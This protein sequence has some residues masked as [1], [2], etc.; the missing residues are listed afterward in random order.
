MYSRPPRR[1]DESWGKDDPPLSFEMKIHAWLDV[2]WSVFFLQFF[3][4]FLS[5]YEAS[6]LRL[7]NFIFCLTSRKKVRW[8]MRQRR[9][10]GPIKSGWAAKKCS[11]S[12]ETIESRTCNDEIVFFH[13]FVVNAFTPI[14]IWQ[15]NQ[16]P[17]V[18]EF[19]TWT[20]NLGNVCC[21]FFSNVTHAMPFIWQVVVWITMFN[22]QL[23]RESPSENH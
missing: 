12:S 22:D 10:R 16:K 19:W 7:K 1:C 11:K 3:Q 9:K 17:D 4:I 8:K 18:S 23:G 2:T 21:Y 14:I 13:L 15:K 6:Q 5:C 20:I